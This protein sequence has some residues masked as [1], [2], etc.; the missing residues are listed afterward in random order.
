[1][2]ASCHRD[3]LL[4]TRRLLAL[5]KRSLSLRQTGWVSLEQDKHKGDG[6]AVTAREEWEGLRRGVG[7]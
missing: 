6:E 1:M 2:S 7:R 5:C 4:G 3:I